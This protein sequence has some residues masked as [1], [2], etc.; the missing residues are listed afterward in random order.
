MYFIMTI[1]TFTVSIFATK[2]E[3]FRLQSLINQIFMKQVITAHNTIFNSDKIQS[4]K[5]QSVLGYF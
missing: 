4:K 3:G 5:P 2:Y 1:D